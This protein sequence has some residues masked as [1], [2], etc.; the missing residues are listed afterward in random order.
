MGRQH[1]YGT[2][3]DKEGM[4]HLFA[5]RVDLCDALKGRRI[6]LFLD[7]DGTLAPIA[8]T[9]D[10]AVMPGKTKELLRRLSKMPGCKIA[11]VSGRSLKD[12]SRR[13]GLKDI[14][15]VGNHGFEIKG[16]KVNFK[17]PVPARYR[18]SLR[19]IKLKLKKELSRFKGVIIEDK[20]FSLSAHYRLADKKDIRRIEAGFYSAVFPYELSGAVRVISG[21]M[22]LEARPPMP[23]NKGKAVLWLLDKEVSLSRDRK[24]KVMPVYIGDDNTDE[25]AFG[26]LRP[27]GITIFVGS[28][29]R[30]KAEF[31]LKDTEEVAQFLEY[32]LK[33]MEP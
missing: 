8:R 32:V 30:T 33:C 9:P 6:Y 20:G 26:S 22:V 18:K 25:D 24:T 31:Y 5:S 15:Y 19:E 7:Y 23:W 28:P 29:R 16:P 3:H 14:V 2:Y 21:K 4:K 11:V 13:V 1:H 10:M 17:F 27:K 12:V